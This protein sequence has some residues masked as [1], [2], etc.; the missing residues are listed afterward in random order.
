[1]YFDHKLS[2]DRTPFHP[3]IIE[4]MENSDILLYDIQSPYMIFL[5]TCRKSENLFRFFHFTPHRYFSYIPTDDKKF[6]S[7]KEASLERSLHK[8]A[9][10]E[11][12]YVLSGS[13]TNRIEDKIFTYEAGQCCV[14]NKNIYHCELFS[15]DFQA[16][17][18]SFREDYLSELLCENQKSQEKLS[19]DCNSNLFFQLF[20]DGLEE[21]TKFEKTYLDCFPLI[22]STE[23]L[24]RLS[25]LFNFIINETLNQQPGSS[26]FVKGAF[27]R[28]FSL[29]NDSNLF[30]INCVHSN[31]SGQEFLFN[32]ISHIIRSSH[33]RCSREELASQ[34][35]Y[36]GE[37][38]NRIV[39]KYTGKTLLS[40]GQSIYLE[41][42]KELLEHSDKNITTIIE[43]LGFS[44]RSHF[45]RLFEKQYGKSPLDYRREFKNQSCQCTAPEMRS[46]LYTDI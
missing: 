12:M 33:G 23:I 10:V 35:H 4:P 29:L 1:M 26:F 45:Y 31:A 17:F 24:D 14:M 38:L 7:Q 42:A 2:F 6:F 27:S 41:E 13:V 9:F 32:K 43:E 15:G 34:L 11:I 20:A 30:N 19:S 8:H 22:P 37:Y 16:V 5:E 39:K 40:Y 36:S 25:P 21:S 28:L 44:N 3:L 46:S 18:F